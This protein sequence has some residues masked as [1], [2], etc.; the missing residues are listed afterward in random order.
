MK[1]VFRLAATVFLAVVAVGLQ[2]ASGLAE[3][4]HTGGADAFSVDMNPF[5]PAANTATT[6]STQ[7]TCAGIKL[8]GVQDADE[9]AI[10]KVTFDVTATQV[11]ALTAMSAFQFDLAHDDV[12]LTVTA[13]DS[14]RSGQQRLDRFQYSVVPI[15]GLDGR[16]ARHGARRVRRRHGRSPAHNDVGQPRRRRPV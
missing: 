13:H 12:K 7:Q 3:A 10:D 2:D 9:D 14:H 11:P 15:P 8:N 1:G 16:R 4:S 6:L 5:G